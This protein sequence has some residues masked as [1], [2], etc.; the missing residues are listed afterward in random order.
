[1]CQMR[2]GA[3][4]LGCAM[5][6][7]EIAQFHS[8]MEAD[9]AD[10]GADGGGNGGLAARVKALPDRLDASKHRACLGG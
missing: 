6:L 9:D 7:I 2:A 1:M 4:K 8:P 5:Q 10:R 3:A